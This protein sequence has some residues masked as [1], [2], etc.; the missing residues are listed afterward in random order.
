VLYELKLYL[1]QGDEYHLVDTTWSE[2]KQLLEHEAK[3]RK[4]NNPDF[5]SVIIDYK[6]INANIV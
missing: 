6:A 1:K 3:E 2:N 5:F 4:A